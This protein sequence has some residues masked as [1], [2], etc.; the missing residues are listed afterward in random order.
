MDKADQESGGHFAKT[1]PP[2]RPRIMAATLGRRAKEHE[3]VSEE[4]RERR[5]A[6]AVERATQRQDAALA[7][8]VGDPEKVK[9]AQEQG[10]K[11][12]LLGKITEKY[13]SLQKDV[14]IGLRLADVPTLKK[15]LADLQ[16]QQ[17]HAHGTHTAV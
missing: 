8:G 6:L 11:E 3:E 7:R 4:E 12:E 1:Q 17:G 16:H 14:P 10:M 13:A 5:R 2:P 15:H 9:Q